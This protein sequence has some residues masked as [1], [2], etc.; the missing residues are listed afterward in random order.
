[1][2]YLNHVDV[3]DP[4]P[5]MHYIFDRNTEVAQNLA[6]FGYAAWTITNGRSES[7]LGEQN[8]S[9]NQIR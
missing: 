4:S 5:F 6:Q 8:V 7:E 3:F 2:G 9:E 1:M